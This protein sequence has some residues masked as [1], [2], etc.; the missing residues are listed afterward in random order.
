MVPEIPSES[1]RILNQ[2]PAWRTGQTGRFRKVE[3][4]AF[5]GGSYKTRGWPLG[6]PKFEQAGWCKNTRVN[7]DDRFTDPHSRKPSKGD[8]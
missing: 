6:W 8:L 5:L 7:T 1:F 4:L 2:N 3:G